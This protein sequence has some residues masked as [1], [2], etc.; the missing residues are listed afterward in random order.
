MKPEDNCLLVG[1]GDSY[2]AALAAQYASAN[3][4]ISC[5]PMDVVMNPQMAD[6]RKVH[7]VS[8]SGNTTANLLAARCAQRRG[9]RTVAVTANA[10]SRLARACDEI[11]HLKY[12]TAGVPTAGTISFVASLFACL[13]LAGQTRLP[14][15]LQEIYEQSEAQA[16]RVAGE[17]ASTRGTY[18]IL[19]DGGL[20]PVALYGT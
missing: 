2:A 5:N 19:G 6:N 1:A 20:F 10:A 11:I 13:S 3:C 9:S 18:L 16:E 8:A 14:A 4:A 7:V 17:I 12:E 15:N